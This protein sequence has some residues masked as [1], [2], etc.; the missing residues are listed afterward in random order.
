MIPQISTQKFES[1]DK[2][3]IIIVDNDM[4]IGK[5]HDFLM[6]V[7]GQMI[8]IMIKNQKE[9]EEK[10]KPKQSELNDKS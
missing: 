6:K 2:K 5:F 10:S 4:S 3:A 9:E 7:K 1:E 8:D